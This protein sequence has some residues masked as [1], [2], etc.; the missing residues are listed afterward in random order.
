MTM[1]K[2]VFRNQD[3]SGAQG[4]ANVF[5]W[6]ILDRITG[7]RIRHAPGPPAPAVQEPSDGL[8]KIPAKGEGMRLTWLGHA[9][10]LIQ[11]DGVSILVD[12][13]LGRS[14]G[15]VVRRLAPMPIGVSELPPVDA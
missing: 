12:P 5:R 15:G 4:F 8:R 3:G 1:A 9:S 2:Q 14:I 7:R 10:W 6:A 13:I 11:L